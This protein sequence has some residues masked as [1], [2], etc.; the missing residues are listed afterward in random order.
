LQ[1]PNQD[2]LLFKDLHDSWETKHNCKV[3]TGTRETF[4]DLFDDDNTLEYEPASTAALIFTGGDEEAE[5]EA[6]EVRFGIKKSLHPGRLA[7]LLQSCYL[8][9]FIIALLSHVS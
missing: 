2:A 4:M 9:L 1:A 5:K 7:V 6:L 3:T 8:H